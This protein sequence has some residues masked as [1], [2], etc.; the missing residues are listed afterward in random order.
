MWLL[1]RRRLDKEA[2]MTEAIRE[3]GEWQIAK[4]AEKELDTL[5]NLQIEYLAY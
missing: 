3:I 5:I 1:W 2:K 4:S